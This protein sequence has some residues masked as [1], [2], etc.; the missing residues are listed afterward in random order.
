MT[1]KNVYLRLKLTPEKRR[2]LSILAALENS[3]MTELLN[4]AIDRLI[5]ENDEMQKLEPGESK[6][7]RSS[8]E[9]MIEDDQVAKRALSQQAECES[10]VELVSTARSLL[11][12]HGICADAIDDYEDI[13]KT[14]KE[15]RTD[16]EF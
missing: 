10:N 14:I 7:K 8:L 12:Y 3:N 13:L 1:E 6:K 11:K 15:S 9:G 2:K 5:S 16:A 4:K